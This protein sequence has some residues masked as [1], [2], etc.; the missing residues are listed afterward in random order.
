MS[1]EQQYALV[2]EDDPDT[3]QLINIVLTTGGFEVYP[4]WDGLDAMHSLSSLHP[5]VIVLDLMMPRMD[6]WAVLEQL[7]TSKIASN[8]P[9]M[10]LTA[11]HDADSQRRARTLGAKDYVKKPFAPADLVSRVQA[12]AVFI[13]EA[14]PPKPILKTF[15][16]GNS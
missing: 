9:V 12:L 14:K 16:Y 10:V 3:N 15:V 13:S 1:A 11:V 6:G 7:R 5:D 8:I 4:A 2:V